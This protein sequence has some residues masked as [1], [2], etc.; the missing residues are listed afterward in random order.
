MKDKQVILREIKLDDN[1]TV[2]HRLLERNGNKFW[3]LIEGKYHIE[4]EMYLHAHVS[5]ECRSFED[6][7]NTYA[8]QTAYACM[9][10]GQKSIAVN[11]FR[12]LKDNMDY[13]LE[14]IK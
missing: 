13:V 7:L 10:D 12:A 14:T 3:T 6:C 11:T 2:I 1:Y 9:V 4:D 5:Y 8:G